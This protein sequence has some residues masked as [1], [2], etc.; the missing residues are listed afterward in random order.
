LATYDRGGN[1]SIDTI[2]VTIFLS[3]PTLVLVIATLCNLLSSN[4]RKFI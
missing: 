1:M 3:L 4:A 2:K